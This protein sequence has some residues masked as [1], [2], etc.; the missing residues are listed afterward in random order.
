[1]TKTADHAI[2]LSY[3]S[4]KES[5]SRCEAWA[6]YHRKEAL[7]P[8]IALGTINGVLLGVG[9]YQRLGLPL[10]LTLLLGIL[11]GNI[12]WQLLNFVLRGTMIRA[13]LASS[14]GVRKL[15]SVLS[16]DGL[17]EH[18][19]E[20][21]TSYPWNLLSDFQFHEGDIFMRCG[22][23]G[24][25]IPREAFE[26]TTEAERFYAMLIA[27]HASNGERWSEFAPPPADR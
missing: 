2:V 14:G 23:E 22:M 27:L 21:I 4:T 18:R 24:L 16:R 26:T 25:Y 13:R 1:M 12:G 3:R 20:G 9:L 15:E 6:A 5:M 10:W 17:T 8:L 19:P 11:L 7:L